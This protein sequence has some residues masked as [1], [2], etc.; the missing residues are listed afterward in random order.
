MKDL[1]KKFDSYPAFSQVVLL[2]VI[3]LSSFVVLSIFFAIIAQVLIPELSELYMSEIRTQYPISFMIINFVPF[4]VGF[5]FVPGYIYWKFLRSN[6]LKFGTNKNIPTAIVL[7]TSVFLLL[8][9]L[10]DVNSYALKYLGW[11]DS[12]I[13]SKIQTDELF[14]SLFQTGSIWPF[15]LGVLIVGVITGI[16]EELLFR[17]FLLRHLLLNFKSPVKAIVVSALAF[18]LLHFNYIQMIPLIFFGLVLGVMYYITGKLWPSIL[19]HTIN[20][21]V[22]IYWIYSENIP[23]WMEESSILLTSIG[24]FLLIS[25]LI[26]A[27]KIDS[28]F[29]QEN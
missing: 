1:I 10:T 21:S 19:M 7:F 26:I 8:P 4:Q 15:I 20:N 18:A 2:F 11:Y 29:S 16:S 17:G 27:K 24:A 13:V 9:F 3:G 5:M 6:S 23:C 25:T 14:S 12:L 22:N 28:S